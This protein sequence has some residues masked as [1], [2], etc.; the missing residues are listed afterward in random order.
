MTVALE[1]QIDGK[2]DF[3]ANYARLRVVWSFSARWLN[4][5]PHDQSLREHVAQIDCTIELRSLSTPRR[6]LLFLWASFL[7]IGWFH[8]SSEAWMSYLWTSRQGKEEVLVGHFPDVLR[9]CHWTDLYWFQI[10]YLLT[11][12]IVLDRM[13]YIVFCAL[14]SSAT[15]S[16]FS[17]APLSHK[18][19]QHHGNFICI[20]LIPIQMDI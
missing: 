7:P 1:H 9:V 17:L 15:Y 8:T 18:L 6:I 10:H 12:T 2:H 11:L 13:K 4:T 19:I 20:T 3:D 5:K 16:A 14:P